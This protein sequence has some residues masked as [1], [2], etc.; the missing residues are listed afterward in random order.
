[1][2]KNNVEF[3]SFSASAAVVALFFS[4]GIIPVENPM[5]KNEYM[6]ER[7]LLTVDNWK[8]LLRRPDF[9]YLG[10]LYVFAVSGSTITL[11]VDFDVT[12]N[13]IYC[14]GAGA[15]GAA[16]GDAFPPPTG[17]GGG[18]GGCAGGCV[19]WFNGA[20]GG[21]GGGGQCSEYVNYNLHAAGQSVPITVGAA[22]T[23]FHNI[24]T[25]YAE[26]AAGSIG[27]GLFGGGRGTTTIRGGNGSGSSA[28]IPQQGGVGGTAAGP[29]SFGAHAGAGVGGAAALT[30]VPGGNGQPYGGGGGGGFGGQGHVGSG[31]AGTAGG[32][33]Y[34]GLVAVAYT[35]IPGGIYY[36]FP[37]AF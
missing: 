6:V 8:S 3:L 27:G 32:A 5:R 10:L 30:A 13:T 1:M 29:T 14:I 4:H 23:M 9:V 11:P 36:F 35:P 26:A 17:C 19:Q 37:T 33:G 24:S 15:G 25:V 28:C 2:L 18:G 22:D 34:Q 7:N 31:D 12:N 16:G 20:G 21:G